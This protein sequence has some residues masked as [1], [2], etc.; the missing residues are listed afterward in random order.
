MATWATYWARSLDVLVAGAEVVVLLRQAEAALLD[1]GDLLGGV[2]EVLLLA[3]AEEGVDAVRCS[4]PMRAASWARLAGGEGVDLVEQRLDGLEA[5]G[6]DGG[7]V[8]AGA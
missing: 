7:G 6:V 4:S 1:E 8:H 2:L 3:V 5:G